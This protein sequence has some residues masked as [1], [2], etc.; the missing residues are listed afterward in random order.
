[1][2][3]ATERPEPDRQGDAPHPRH[4]PRLFGQDAA[5]AAVL[6]AWN[7][8][9]MPHGW[10]LTGPRGVGKATLAWRMARFLVTDPPAR[11]DDLDPAPGHPALRRLGALSHAG[12][13]LL[14]RPWDD[15][16]GRLR[17]EI[18]VEEARR[19]NGF[20]ALSAGGRRVVIVDAAD[21]LNRNAAN[22]ILKLLE[23]PP[24][25]ATILLVAH[26]PA[27]IL[28]TIRSRC[29]SLALHPLDEDAMRAALRQ[30]G[31]DVTPAVLHLAEG[32]VGAALSI[33]EG[34]ASTYVSLVRCLGGPMMDRGAARTLADG[35]TGRANAGKLDVALD[36]V[37]RLAHRAARAAVLGPSEPI[38]AQEPD[39]LRRLAPDL[40]AAQALIDVVQ[41]ALDRAAHA[42][43]VNVDPSAILWDVL[44]ALDGHAASV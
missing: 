12:L 31:A 7:G 6:A 37:R 9:R 42:Q 1:M 23:E 22:A 21:D 19:L 10:M 29:R 36:M 2:T 39:A 3:D 17:T 44:V 5:E 13:L 26:R 11:A 32:S 40:A 25:G 16:A 24:E 41:V 33:A 27:A 43:A 35:M 8:G 14:R 34:G 4:T 28:P 38:T 15:K 18:T 30:A 20:F